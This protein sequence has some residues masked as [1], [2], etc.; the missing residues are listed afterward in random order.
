MP[1]QRLVFDEIASPLGPLVI[2]AAGPALCALHYADS[3]S[4]ITAL[5][6]RRFGS[7]SLERDPDPRG[8]SSK[9]RAYFSGDL[10]ALDSIPV[11]TGG[12]FFQQQVWAALRRIP[13]GTTLSYR[14]L[15]LAIQRPAA[16]RAVGAA[17]ARNPIAIVIPCHRVIG[18]DSSLTGYAGGLSRKRWLLRHEGCESGLLFPA[19]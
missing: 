9:L 14:E 2:A 4:R 3:P 6:K 5:L 1:G 10:T 16:V 19:C 18:A 15:A 13:P 12:T 7:L 17:N 11:S 8:F